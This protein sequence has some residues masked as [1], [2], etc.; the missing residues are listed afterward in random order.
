[1]GTTSRPKPLALF[2]QA[3]A[4]YIAERIGEL[5]THAVLHNGE[6]C[7]KI[8]RARIGGMLE[9]LNRMLLEV[10]CN[11]TF[12]DRDVLIMTDLDYLKFKEAVR[13]SD[14]PV[15]PV[16]PVQNKTPQTRRNP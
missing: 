3:D 9:V 6:P 13:A 7:A 12:P 10:H 16:N 8:N 5:H 15:N 4:N 1:M 11:W 2:Y 14:N